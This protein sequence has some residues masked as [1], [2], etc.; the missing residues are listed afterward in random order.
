MNDIE[1]GRHRRG[2]NQ[3]KEI[4]IAVAGAVLV[5]AGATYL[6]FKE[7]TPIK[8]TPAEITKSKSEKE[9]SAVEQEAVLEFQHIANELIEQYLDPSSPEYEGENATVPPLAYYRLTDTHKVV[10]KIRL[11]ND[12]TTEQGEQY[13]IAAAQELMDRIETLVQYPELDWTGNPEHDL[14]LVQKLMFELKDALFKKLYYKRNGTISSQVDTGIINCTVSRMTPII[15]EAAYRLNGIDAAKLNQYRAA[16]SEQHISTA[17]IDS[18]ASAVLVFEEQAISHDPFVYDTNFKGAPVTV[19][20]LNQHLVEYLKLYA[21]DLTN[22][23]QKWIPV[24]LDDIDLNLPDIVI[25]LEK[26]EYDLD[27]NG[28]ERLIPIIPPPGQNDK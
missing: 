9:P 25:S 6:L 27:E 16:R 10:E 20:P 12:S 1:H 18:S 23:Q 8:E 14:L 13:S 5:N 15:L 28:E 3:K 7:P 11:N 2:K 19:Y 22:E 17:V 26:V 21:T 24:T 4:A